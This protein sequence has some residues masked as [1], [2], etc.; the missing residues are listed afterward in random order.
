MSRAGISTATG[1]ARAESG[2]PDPIKKRDEPPGSSRFTLVPDWQ[3]PACQAA[4][5]ALERGGFC[6]SASLVGGV[7]AFP[8]EDP[9]GGRAVRALHAAVSP[10]GV[11]AGYAEVAA[12]SGA[13][14]CFAYDAAPVFEP[15]RD[16]FPLDALRTG[17]RALGLNGRWLA[18]RPADDTLEQIGGALADGRPAV[19]PLY[20][21][22]GIHGFVVAVSC[23]P[24]ERRL[25]VQDGE[26]DFVAGMS[27][28]V[29]EIQLPEAWSGAVTGPLAWAACPAFLV[30]RGAPLGWSA[31]GRLQRALLRGAALLAGGHMPYRDCEGA[32]EFAAVPLGGRQCAYGLPAYD[33]LAADVGGAEWLGGFDL[34]W[35]MDAQVTQLQHNRE[36]LARFLGSLPHPLAEEAAALCRT[37]AAEAADLAGRFWFRPTRNMEL[38]ADVMAAAGSSPAMLYWIGFSGEERAKLASRM[39]VVDTR[40]GPAAVVD[41]APRRREAGALVRSMQRREEKLVRIVSDLA[42]A[43]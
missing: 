1:R 42:N 20:S 32:R 9:A 17:V 7:P 38:A 27:P 36:N 22:E 16:L 13:A 37:T 31:E 14:F 19:V 2:N 3:G 21:L 41:T 35:R 6:L 25:Y 43:L 40:W 39:P 34:I 15:Q 30:E 18:N 12:L 26:R 33:A 10:L 28:T 11:T 29:R 23:D 5:S 8:H 24:A 4:K